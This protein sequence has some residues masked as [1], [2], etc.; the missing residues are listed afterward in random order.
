MLCRSCFPF[1][2]GSSLLPHVPGLMEKLF[3][4]VLESIE[5]SRY[6]GPALS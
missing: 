4:P 2:L 3:T 1:L 6:A 5:Q